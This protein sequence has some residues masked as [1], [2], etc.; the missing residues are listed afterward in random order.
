MVKEMFT[1]EQ[2]VTKGRMSAPTRSGRLN[3]LR[4]NNRGGVEQSNAR[5]VGKGEV[6]QEGQQNE[7]QHRSEVFEKHART[8]HVEQ[9]QQKEKVKDG[10][11]RER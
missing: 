4:D 11:D 9:Q 3:N 6:K 7:K 5:Q 2:K 10:R 1:E 8:R